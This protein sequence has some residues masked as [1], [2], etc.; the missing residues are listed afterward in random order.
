MRL[1]FKSFSVQFTVSPCLSGIFHVAIRMVLFLLIFLLPKFSEAQLSFGPNA[2]YYNSHYSIR[3]DTTKSDTLPR[4]KMST[5]KKAALMS[6]CLPGLGQIYNGKWWK[7]PIIYAGF[8][9]LA[10]G[11]GWNEKY[12]KVYRNALRYRYDNDPNTVDT[13]TRYSDDDLVVQKNYYEH[14]R[15][16]CVIGMAALYTLQIIDATVDAHLKTFD[17]SDNLSLQ[18]SPALYP[19]RNGIVGTIGFRLYYR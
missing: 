15:D 1:I 3:K 18:V 16:L 12:F 7:T 10:Y 13:L 17:V 9:G 11:F 14:Y 4:K 19:S 5:P 2:D 6:A 8:G